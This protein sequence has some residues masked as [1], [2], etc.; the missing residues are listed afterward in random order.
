MILLYIQILKEVSPLFSVP[1]SSRFF[2]NTH[3]SQVVSLESTTNKGKVKLS[4]YLTK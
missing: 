2:L 1:M 3:V 4:L